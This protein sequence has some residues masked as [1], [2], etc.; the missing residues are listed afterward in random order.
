VDGEHQRRAAAFCQR[1]RHFT[2]TESMDDLA[3]DFERV[4]REARAD[5]LRRV[6]G[7]CRD[8]ASIAIEGVLFGRDQPEGD[9][10]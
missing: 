8:Q 10:G 2:T 5:T 7:A 4:A 6:A 9:G 1:H 3:A